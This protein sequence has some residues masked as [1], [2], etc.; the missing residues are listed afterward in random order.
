MKGASASDAPHTR[1]NCAFSSDEA[2]HRTQS[3][4]DPPVSP[5]PTTLAGA[6]AECGSSCS[7]GGAG[8]VR[9]RST[10]PPTGRGAGVASAIGG[11]GDSLGGGV[12]VGSGAIGWPQV[13]QKRTLRWLELPHEPHVTTSGAV[14]ASRGAKLMSGAGGR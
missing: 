2:R 5:R 7:G 6:I 8:T 12:G 9:D 13:T 10:V 14:R 4:C 11:I 1:Q 3:L